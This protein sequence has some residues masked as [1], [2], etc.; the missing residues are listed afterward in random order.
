MGLE[1]HLKKAA[2]TMAPPNPTKPQVFSPL[3]CE[4]KRANQGRGRG[5]GA[6]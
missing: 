1:T 5:G 6:Q 2:R 4:A 3:P